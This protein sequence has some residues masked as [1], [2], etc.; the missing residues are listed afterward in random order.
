LSA[1]VSWSLLVR[2]TCTLHATPSLAHCHRAELSRYLST[3]I[4][5]EICSLALKIILRL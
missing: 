3:V 4:D 1:W 5:Q 2:H